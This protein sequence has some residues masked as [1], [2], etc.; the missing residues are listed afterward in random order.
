MRLSELN[1]L[2]IDPG[3]GRVGYGLILAR[4]G[5]LHLKTYGVIET[6]KRMPTGERLRHIHAA[7]LRLISK[8]H[9]DR[10][11]VEK[12]FFSK[13]IKTATVVGEARGVILLVAAEATIPVVDYSPQEVKQAVTGYGN[14]EK[15][16]LQ[17]MVQAL[18]RL[19][20]PPT[21]DDAA[22]AIALAVCG[23]QQSLR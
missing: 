17:R 9:P 18:F 4:G 21:P 8:H 10:I 14:A 6:S 22:D 16:Q 12:L 7:L 15:R 20:R 23:A 11:A 13:N 3:I 2:G 1:I 19:K 5:D